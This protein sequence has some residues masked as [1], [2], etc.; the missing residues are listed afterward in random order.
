VTQLATVGAPARG[1]PVVD[2]RRASTGAR[3]VTL[4]GVP[5]GADD[6]TRERLL[7]ERIVAG[8]ETALAA[9]YDAWSSF[10]FAL[11]HRICRDRALAEDVTQEVFLHLWERADAFDAARASLRTWLGMLA[12]R[13]SVDRVRREEA[14]RAR[15]EREGQRAAMSVADVEERALQAVTSG[16]VAHALAELPADQRTC[17]VLAYFEGMTFK[18][19]A[20]ALAIPEGTAKSRIRLALAK[21]A[22]ALEGTTTWI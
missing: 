15:E 4:R 13:R 3:T 11:S 9:V 14:R 21:L 16:S 17:V 20:A 18:E 10:V 6:T 19:V 12:H 5:V 8:D 22:D 2:H 1:G 7:V